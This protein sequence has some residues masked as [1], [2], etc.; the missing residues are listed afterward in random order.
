MCFIPGKR[1]WNI[2]LVN[3]GSWELKGSH[4]KAQ[5]SHAIFLAEAGVGN[6]S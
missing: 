3:S 4:R 1:F 2:V 6:K 5:R